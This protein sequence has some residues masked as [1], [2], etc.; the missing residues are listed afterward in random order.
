[1]RNILLIVF[2]FSCS[3]VSSQQFSIYQ[4]ITTGNGLPSN[5]V[6]S[7]CED[8]RGYLWVGTDKGL[9]RYNGFSW[10]VWDKDNGLPGNYINGI[11]ADKRGGLWL[12]ISEKGWFHFDIEKGVSTKITLPESFVFNSF[13]PDA[14]G[15]LL[16]E[17]VKGKTMAGYLLQPGSLST[18][19][20]VYEYDA[21]PGYVIRPNA[22]TKQ[23]ICVTG[24]G[25][26]TPPV[27]KGTWS[28]LLRTVPGDYIPSALYYASDRLVISSRQSV[29]YDSYG[30]ATKVLNLFNSDNTYAVNCI[31]SKGYYISNIRT[32]YYF[33]NEKSEATFY[34]GKSGLGSDYINQLYELKDGT[35]VFATLGAGLQFKRNE[36]KRTYQTGNQIVRSILKEGSSWYALVGENI[37]RINEVD[38]QLT[39]MGVVQPAALSM[40]KNGNQLVI[41]SLKGINFYSFDKGIKPGNFIYYNSGVSSII[42]NGAIYYASTYGDGFIS[43]NKSGKRPA[44]VN[45]IM[46]IIEKTLPLING[47]AF[48]SYEDGIIITDTLHSKQLHLTLK[49]GLISN[50][51]H[52]IHEY[53]GSYYIGSKGGLSIYTDGRVV[54]TLTYNEGF[55]G[56]KVIY[57]FHDKGSRLWVVSDKYLHVFD[58]QKLRV[59]SSHPIVSDVDDMINTACYDSTINQLATGSNKNISILSIAGI[60]PN[61]A[62]S[63]PMVLQTVVDGKVHLINNQAVPYDFNTIAFSIAPF[64]TSPLAKNKFLYLMKGKDKAWKEVEDSLS[65]TYAALRPGNYQLMAKIIN[66]DGYES[67]ET[68]VAAFSVKKPFWQTGWLIAVVVLATSLLTILSL[69]LIEA[70]RR[71]KRQATL[72][73][74]Q[75]LRNERERISKDLHDHLGSNLVNIVA[76]VDT[77]EN[78]LN[79]KSFP[80]AIH[81]VQKL[82]LHAR[83]VINVLRETVWAVQENEHSMESFII[84]IRTFLQRMY[85][86][87]SITWQVTLP[88]GEHQNLSSKQTL[89]LFR[90]IQEATQN[91]LKHSK[92]T[93]ADY[94]F[95]VSEKTLEVIITDNGIGFINS[96]KVGQGLAN[97][98][99]RAKDMNASISIESKKGT[100]INLVLPGLL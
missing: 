37:L 56:K 5:Y 75:S 22:I 77:I 97:M 33:I 3:L 43:F 72:L 80:E 46:P 98:Q 62:V 99:Q 45:K 82:S 26:A 90:V 24:E 36:Y 59:I 31:T 51:I 60:Q 57:S 44:I 68:Q 13:Q 9:C 83:E 39:K 23:L 92:A 19:E 95:S 55:V 74:D 10:Q 53:K 41:G 100:R 52:T 7:V 35:I 38:S 84:R 69:N 17:S 42:Q 63:V 91:I 86:S 29:Q 1:M 65:I 64:A 21:T 66:P 27:I 70:Y 89:H 8:E 32:G 14:L 16:V 71:R 50:S 6:F 28:F 47:Y 88:A 87:T 20:K 54:K 11:F 49:D 67:K 61:K 18:P 93:T 81:S 12:S 58:G 79:R 94:I 15:N 73:L 2:L 48:L 76:Q 96:S 40:Y 4:G 78:R 30:K 25:K 85:E 34:N